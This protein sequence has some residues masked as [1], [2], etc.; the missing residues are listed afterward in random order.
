M[1]QRT[2]ELNGEEVSVTAPDDMP[3]LWVLRDEVGLTGPKYGCGI[4]MCGACS[5]HLDGDVV[6]SCQIPVGSLPANQ[7][8]TTIEGLGPE[9]FEPSR[10]GRVDRGVRAAV[11]LLSNWDDHGCFGIAGASHRANRRRYRCGHVQYL[12]LR[13][14]SARSQSH[15]DRNRQGADN[16][17]LNLSLMR[18]K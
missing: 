9:W 12:P 14:L 2:F 6:R 8:I 18:G 3:L 5:V 16:I 13:N 15:P 1:T 7:K 4:G 11:R 10:A 17:G